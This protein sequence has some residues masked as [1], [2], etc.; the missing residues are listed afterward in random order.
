MGDDYMLR[1]L[2]RLS[3]VGGNCSRR[4]EPVHSRASFYFFVSFEL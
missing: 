3:C 2:E 4:V 1:E